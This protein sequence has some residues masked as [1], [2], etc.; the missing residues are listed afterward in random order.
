LKEHAELHHHF[1]DFSL[2]ASGAAS[3]PVRFGVYLSGFSL[4]ASA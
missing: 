1:F 2:P 4:I 3:M